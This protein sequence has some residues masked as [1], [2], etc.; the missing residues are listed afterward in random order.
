MSLERHKPGKTNRSLAAKLFAKVFTNKR[1]RV[2]ASR[3]MR[4]FSGQEPSSS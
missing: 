4:I 2:Q 3:I 1:M